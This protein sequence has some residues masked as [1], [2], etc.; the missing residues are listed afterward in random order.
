MKGVV[1]YR[2]PHF[3]LS[4]DRTEKDGL[5]S[6]DVYSRW[7]KARTDTAAHKL[8]NLNLPV[9]DMDKLADALKSK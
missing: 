2:Q 4:V 7:P 5:V 6:V 3:E 9:A 1:V 8:L